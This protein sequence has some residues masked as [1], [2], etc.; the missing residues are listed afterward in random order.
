MEKRSPF[1]ACM[2]FYPKHYMF[3]RLI[4]QL[5]MTI[6]PAHKILSLTHR[7]CR[8]KPN[9][10][11][12]PPLLQKNKYGRCQLNRDQIFSQT[13]YLYNRKFDWCLIV[14]PI[15]LVWHTSPTDP[16]IHSLNH[17]SITYPTCRLRGIFLQKKKLKKIFQK[18]KR[19]PSLLWKAFQISSNYFL[20]HRHF[21]LF[22]QIA[23]PT[24]LI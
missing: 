8:G 13:N 20:L 19:H 10:W 5:L 7:K 3:L 24:K 23:S 16:L 4:I 6:K 9:K 12:L 2:Q 14:D 17:P 15:W 21:K 1:I 11:I 18:G 22:I